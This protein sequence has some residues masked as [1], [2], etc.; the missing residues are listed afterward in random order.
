MNNSQISVIGS[1]AWGSAISNLI[2]KNSFLVSLSTNN[3]KS[4]EEI[5]QKHSNKKYLPKIKLD[6]NVTAV[7]G[8]LEK[9]L[10]KSELIFI[11]TPSN[12]VEKILKKISS[13]KLPENIG[14]VI[15]SKGLDHQKLKFFSQIFEEI[16]PNQKYAILSGPNFANEV[17]HEVPSVTTI[18]SKDKKFATKVIKVLQNDYFCAEFSDDPITTEICG[19][20]KN[21]IAIGCGIVDGL[22][23]GQNA[24]AALVNKGIGEIALLCKKLKGQ[25]NLNNAAGF[26]DI[27][28]TCSTTKSRNNS[29]GYEIAKGKSYLE[30]SK[31]S[32]KTFEG[33]LSAKSVVKLAKKLKLQLIL[34]EKINQILQIS[35]SPEEIK[36]IITKAILSK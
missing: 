36:A 3:K 32:K 2:A 19:I 23:L 31:G 20:M 17:A 10:T 9:D 18:A 24:K 30:I 25:G 11:V 21:I 22:N 15:C 29:L 1:G 28:L 35:L 7:V 27:F 4:A 26:G 12:T 6:K 13:F 34:S 33:A 8:L 5:N 14:F 16:L